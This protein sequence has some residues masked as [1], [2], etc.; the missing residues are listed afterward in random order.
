MNA[1][2]VAHALVLAALG[3]APSPSAPA[4]SFP[5]EIVPLLGRQGCSSAYCHGSATGRGGF[6]LSLFGSD[7][8]DDYRAV[9]EALD[10]RRVDL[11]A[12]EESLLVEKPARVVAHGGGLR[13]DAG[14]PEYR[15]VVDWIARGAPYS[16]RE[17]QVPV[18]LALEPCD[19]GVRAVATLR[20]G[21]STGG[22]VTRDV[23]GL[24]V[25]RS[26][27]DAVA[28]VDRDGHVTL[29]GR[30]TAWI[31]ASWAQLHAR[32]EVIVPFDDADADAHAGGAA[33]DAAASDDHAV[34]AIA[35]DVAID[36]S[37]TDSLDD[38]WSARLRRL[39]LRP[40][41][42]ASGDVLVRRLHLELAG[43]PP[44]PDELDAFF[45]LPARDRIER[46]ARRLLATR[47]FAAVFAAHL[48]RWLEVPTARA[49]SQP[50]MRQNEGRDA[51]L[52][53]FLVESIEARRPLG[54][55]AGAVLRGETAGDLVTRFGDARDR[56]EFVG[57]AFLGVRIGCARCHNHPLDR[58]TQDDHLAFS[59]FFTDPRPAPGGGQE[60]GVLFDPRSGAVVTPRLL[61]APASV[62]A[63]SGAARRERVGAFVLDPA[64]GL[65]ARAIANRVFA[66]LIGRG[67]VEP[68]DDHRASNPAVDEALLDALA[69]RF[70][71][72]GGDL[73]DLVLAIVTSRV[74]ALSSEPGST[75]AL[76]GDREVALLA[77]REALGLEPVLLERSLRFAVGVPP[78]P[79]PADGSTLPDAP[80]A[81]SLALLNGPLVH[82][83]LAAR[84]TQIDAV[85]D[86]FDEPRAQLIEIWRQLL[87]RRPSAAEIDEF[88]P[89][90]ETAEDPREVGRDLAFALLS[91]REFGT[92]R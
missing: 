15:A 1:G 18:S 43:R 89:L 55:T 37:S 38:V 19:G 63:S 12:P 73:R 14:T 84:D 40:A 50:G 56:A 39:G 80:L 88:L 90:F 49:G 7:P 24:A 25:F 8:H 61:P 42:P 70:T 23:S 44:S 68:L 6:K 52:R 71:A 10:G 26:S 60:D 57:R 66:A 20:A 48:G 41:P 3:D 54:E 4:I 79:A 30:G 47:D 9:V 53:A 91:S 83:L 2:L 51:R 32:H 45:A 29:R 74:W 28:S 31:F 76:P 13:L 64:H 78:L 46:T 22:A 65:F 69:A 62:R 77:R 86:V 85:F 5:Y 34:D 92:L 75:L 11:R 59:A 82:E 58:W 67:L 33:G 27:D 21:G 17:P 87:S 35:G 72:S 16:S 36:T 81:R